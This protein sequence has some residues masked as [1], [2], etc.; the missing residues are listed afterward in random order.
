MALV[1]PDVAMRQ[2][3]GHR[4]QSRSPR[5]QVIG[6]QAD[7]PNLISRDQISLS[8]YVTEDAVD[9]GFTFRGL[10]DVLRAQSELAKSQLTSN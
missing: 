1:T 3:P 6:S 4:P 5:A 2:P 9:A 10:N 7:K 8:A